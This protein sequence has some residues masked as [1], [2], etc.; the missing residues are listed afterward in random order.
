MLRKTPESEAKAVRVH[1]IAEVIPL[2]RL[3]DLAF[4]LADYRY[5]QRVVDFAPADLEAEA[6]FGP[7]PE[8][9][10]PGESCES[11]FRGRKA[12]IRSKAWA[13][14]WMTLEG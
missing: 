11:V 3:A 5:R 4:P 6:M 7:D 1:R 10:P 9:I 12:Q 2:G 14:M 13:Q 8:D